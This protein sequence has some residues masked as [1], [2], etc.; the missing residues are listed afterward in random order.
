MGWIKGWAKPI[1]L[2]FLGT[3]LALGITQGYVIYQEHKALVQWAIQVNQRATQAA[4]PV[5]TPAPAPA[6][7]PSPSKK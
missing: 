4:A 6:P 7:S 2:G 1:L 5:L 3:F